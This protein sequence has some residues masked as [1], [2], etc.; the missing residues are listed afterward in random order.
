MTRMSR[1]FTLT[2]LGSGIL[3][4]GYFAAPDPVEE[5]Q[6]KADVQAAHRVG[7]THHAG[8]F[9]PLIWVHSPGYSGSH[10]GRPVSSHAG[11]TR[12]GIGGVGRSVSAGS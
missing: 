3:T 7:G 6:Q 4:A 5:I 12:G 2:L 11:V 8:Y 9:H 10:M 1:E